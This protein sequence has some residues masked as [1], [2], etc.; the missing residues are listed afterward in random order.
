MLFQYSRVLSAKMYFDDSTMIQQICPKFWSE[1]CPKCDKKC[2]KIK[3]PKQ[4][5][6]EF[7]VQI[8]LQVNCSTW[9]TE[10]NTTCK[11]A[12]CQAH[13]GLSCLCTFEVSV[14]ASLL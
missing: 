8:F 5:I 12:H 11:L 6:L 4:I 3:N 10:D 1:I 7:N 14:Y 9:I 2:P 13:A